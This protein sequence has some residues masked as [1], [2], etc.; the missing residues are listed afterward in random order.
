MYIDK[1]LGRKNMLYDGNGEISSEK[2]SFPE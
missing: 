1:H 2:T